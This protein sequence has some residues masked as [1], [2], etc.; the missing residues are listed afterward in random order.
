M[1]AWRYRISLPCPTRCHRLFLPNF[2]SEVKVGNARN[3]VRGWRLRA[4]VHTGL[5]IFCDAAMLRFRII[6]L[7]SQLFA[8]FVK[9]RIIQA[10]LQN[11]RKEQGN[12][13]FLL[14]SYDNFKRCFKVI[15]LSNDVRNH[16]NRPRAFD[17]S[18]NCSM[19]SFAPRGLGTSFQ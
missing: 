10:K 1:V 19:R 6:D 4:W 2:F 17:R 12:I 9:N 8:R 5:L 15:Y 14:K 13:R 3:W 18:N 7:K 16:Q 11:S